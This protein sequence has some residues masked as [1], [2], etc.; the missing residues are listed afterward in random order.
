MSEPST[1]N[2]SQ[3]SSVERAEKFAMLADAWR[4][5]ASVRLRCESDP[6]G[7]LA[8]RA[9]MDIPPELEVRILVNTDEEFHVVFPLDPNTAISDEALTAVVGGNCAGSAGTLGTLGSAGTIPSTA[10]TAGTL[11]CAGTAG[12]G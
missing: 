5:D 1:E 7:I 8:D 11:F 2:F 4:E 6:R 12:T 3:T 10:S 9:D